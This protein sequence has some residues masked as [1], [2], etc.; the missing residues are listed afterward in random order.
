MIELCSDNDKDVRACAAYALGNSSGSKEV[1]TL[2]NELL[3]QEYVCE[4]AEL[5]LDLLDTK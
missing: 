4:Y 3:S 2:L 1:R 5:G